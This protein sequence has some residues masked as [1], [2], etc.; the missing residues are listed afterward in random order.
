M[1]ALTYDEMVTKLIISFPLRIGKAIDFTVAVKKCG[2]KSFLVYSDIE[3]L[4]SSKDIANEMVALLH[5]V[6]D[7]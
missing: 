4:S 3:S 1:N 6:F 7:L 5:H 2:I